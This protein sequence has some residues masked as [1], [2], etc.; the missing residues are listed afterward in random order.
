MHTALEGGSKQG[1]TLC[2][3]II[4]R[5]L[6]ELCI[7]DASCERP[8]EKGAKQYLLAFLFLSRRGA[9]PSRIC[10]AGFCT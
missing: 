10:S 2:G 7:Y 3:L 5:K 6:F 4:T 9:S 1:F 8:H